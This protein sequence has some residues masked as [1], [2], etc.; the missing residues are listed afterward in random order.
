[1]NSFQFQNPTKLLF[2]PDKLNQLGQEISAYGKKVLLVYG[3]GSIKSTGLYDR[4]LQQLQEIQA[5]V[6]EL[7]GV[8]PNPRLTTVKKGID[9]CRQHGVE[10]ILAVGGGSVLDAAKAVA[11]GVPYDGDVWDFCIRKAQ[12]Q[13]AL[14]LGTV[15]TL[16]ATGS[17]MNGNSVITN[18][19][20][21]LKKSFGSIHAYPKFSILDPTLTY[22]VPAN[23]T[24]NGIV[25]M[26]SHV[27]EQYF[28]P[29]TDTPLQ[30]R[31]CESILQTV[32][33]NGELALQNPNDYA[34]RANIMLCGTYA[35]NGGM[36]SIGMQ[37]DWATHMIEHEVSAIYD[38]AHAEGLSV[39]FPN[40]MKY[41][42]QER[43]DRFVQYAVRV[44]QIDP[45]GKT[46]NEIALAGIQATR[47]YF[48]RIGAPSRL[49]DLNIDGK[50]LDR[51]AKETVRFGPVGSFKP[52]NESDVRQILEMSL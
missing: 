25:D 17:E 7:A 24:V 27:F 9:L 32:I 23:Q 5:E 52:L 35:L 34:S 45:N 19:E 46:D 29:T 30:E 2:G 3:G 1:M 26:M 14:P 33:E 21:N 15:L 28:S 12:I 37:N 41:V 38:I 16:S 39:L 18:W 51:M 43:I 4:I 40:W 44:W 50:E 22:S 36:I 49:G 20:E 31:L 48:T 11:A 13:T 10:F 8:E 6:H 47:D 42:Y